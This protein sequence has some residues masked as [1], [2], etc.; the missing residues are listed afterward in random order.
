MTRLAGCVFALLLLGCPPPPPKVT[1]PPP[2]YQPYT[3]LL[4]GRPLEPDV[5]SLEGEPGRPRPG[6]LV[7]VNDLP[8]VLDEQRRVELFSGGEYPE[9]WLQQRTPDGARRLVAV[10]VGWTYEKTRKVIR[11]PLAKL[12][13]EQLRA[14]R[15]IVLD[16]WPQGIVARLQQLDLARTCLTITDSTAQG[17]EKAAPPLP[18]GLRYL[19]VRER[20]NRGIASFASLTRLRSLRVLALKVMT[21]R[22][23]DLRQVA[24]NTGLRVLDLSGAEL[25]GGSSLAALTELRQLDLSVSDGIT[26]LSPLSAL[27]QLRWI[28]LE[29]TKV[30]SL[31]PLGPLAALVK[32]NANATRVARL[33]EGVLPEL[34]E[35]KLLSTLVSRPDVDRFRA[36]H[37]RCAVVHGWMDTLS[38]AVALAGRLR[39][40]TGGTCH[41][42]PS[43]ERTIFEV[44]DPAVI[45]DFVAKLEVDEAKSGF[46]CMCCGSPSLELYDGARLLAT[47]GFHHGRSLR[48]PQRWPGDALLTARSAEH[49]VQ[50]LGKHGFDQPLREREEQRARSAATQRRAERYRLIIPR[51]AMA[52]LSK[53]TSRQQ[54]IAA[55]EQ[56][57]NGAVRAA[58]YLRLFG[59]DSVAW[60]IYAGLDS[61]LTEALL[62]TLDGKDLAAALQ[63]GLKDT[64]VV[65]G[66]ARWLLSEKKSDK[67]PVKALAAALPTLV[68]A[69]LQSARPIN[70]RRTIA[71]L[72][73]LK[74]PEATRAL[75]EQLAKPA[76][77]TSL[78]VD[79]VS[80]PDGMIAYG[81][82][83]SAVP[84]GCSDRAY[85]ALGLAQLKDK[86]SLPAIRKLVAR[87]EGDDKTVL[88]QAVDLLEGR[89]PKK[90]AD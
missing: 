10:K 61:M 14:L 52:A 85:A 59:C 36:A 25:G 37:P 26:D 16:E 4:D 33:P 41:R 29:R 3:F 86:R 71:A 79:E 5:Y 32:I 23:F 21:V 62:P 45:R 12:T 67:V 87:A 77:P 76:P 57:T 50:F 68:R 73:R 83:D 75:R 7:V 48:W 44:N 28:D 49:L 70:R 63:K 88:Q 74:T 55:F 56:E 66:A 40:R 35:L 81:P 58:L 27:R 39:V 8:F 90:P 42:R 11:D 38:K 43:T 1:V 6:D 47:L 15:G 72:I 69:G 82:D 53:A 60:N 13:A 89:A 65:N 18:E 78:P 31:A 17:K 54:A 46:H 80:Q 20:S 9:S 22:P 24:Q 30:G 51:E 2:P 34:R 19:V 64:A 84:D